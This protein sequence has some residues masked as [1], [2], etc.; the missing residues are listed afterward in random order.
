MSSSNNHSHHH[1]HHRHE[2]EATKFKR[3]SLMAIEMRKKIAKWTFR[4][5]CVIAVIMAIAVV[6]V[7]M[8]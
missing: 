3:R 8:L 1:H 5:L 7:Y 4:A 6:I 2:D